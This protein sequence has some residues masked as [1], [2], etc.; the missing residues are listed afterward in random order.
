ML[1]QSQCFSSPFKLSKSDLLQS[2]NPSRIAQISSCL[3]ERG[4]QLSLNGYQL[5]VAKSPF[6]LYGFFH[7]FE[8][9][10]GQQVLL[11]AQVEAEQLLEE[12]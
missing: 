7:A 3:Q 6:Q 9:L 8:E 10:K 5:A 11:L 2:S 4:R 1:L 12:Q